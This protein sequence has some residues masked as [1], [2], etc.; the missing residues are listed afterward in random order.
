MKHSWIFTLLSFALLASLLACSSSKNV[1]QSLQKPDWVQQR[2]INTSYYIGIGS[3][4]KLRNPNDYQRVAKKNALDDLMGE[5]KV[6]VSSHSVLLQQQN[7]QQFSQQFFSDTKLIS[8]ET[9]EGFEVLGSW[10]NTQDFFI[11]YRF[12]KAE[13]EAQKRR[14]LMEA[15]EKAKDFLNRAD[16]LSVQ[17]DYTASLKLR[18]K[19]A[20]SLQNYLNEAIEA[21]YK[22]RSVYLMNE[23]LAQIQNQLYLV[24]LK[25]S[26]TIFKV[27]AGKSLVQPVMVSAQVRENDKLGLKIEFLPLQLQG[28]GLRFKGN[29]NAETQSNG[30]AQFILNNIQGATGIRSIQAKIDI[31][32]IIAG[33]SLL[34]SMRRLLLN[35][36]GPQA[37]LQLQ[38]EPIKIY[39]ESAEKNMQK[40]MNFGVLEPAVKK[41]LGDLGCAFVGKK[42]ESDYV[43]HLDAETKDQ[44]IMW[45]QML[46]ASIE[47]NLVLTDTKTSVEL[48]HEAI[49]G[50]TGFQVTPEKAG[51]DAYNNMRNEMNKKLL[52]AIQ[53]RL[54]PENR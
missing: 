36:E 27:S 8:S 28:N 38:V 54:F 50:V 25:T 22:G 45:G 51:M 37:T 46:R 49:T 2:P 18:F 32:K 42:E 12:S 19:A 9:L 30:E 1:Q 15:I 4:N 3:A 40:Q 14:K 6:S 17:N 31:A 10:E 47:M 7:N 13:F 24:Q 21:D 5:I 16:N 52:P 44:G 35:L 33:D 41:Y 29:N 11:Y 39:L 48:I 34:P 43:L 20:I 53:E 26:E 23:V